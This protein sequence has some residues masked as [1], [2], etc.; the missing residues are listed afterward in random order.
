M[1][2]I[3][4]KTGHVTLETGINEDKNMAWDISYSKME[5]DMMAR[6]VMDFVPDWV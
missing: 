2:D 4:T 6:L 1:A 5:H 3:V